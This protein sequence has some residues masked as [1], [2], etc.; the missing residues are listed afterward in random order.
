M[1]SFDAPLT[2]RAPPAGFI[3]RDARAPF[4]ALSRRYVG[5]PGGQTHLLEAGQ[6]SN[7]PSLWCLH[8]TAYAGRSFAPLLEALAGRRRVVAPDTM[9]YGG[10]DKPSEPIEI[11]DYARLIDE[12]LDAAGEGRIDL[13]GYHT[14]ALVAAELAGLR[15]DRVRRL[16]LIGVPYL[17][18]H[19]QKAWRDRLAKPAQL[20][21]GLEQFQERWDFLVAQRD[22]SVSLKRAFENFVDE[23]RAYPDGWWAHDAAFTFDVAGCFAKVSQPV[24]I[25]NPDNPLASPSRRAAKRL[26]NVRIVELKHLSHGIFDRAPDEIAFL[27]EA[28]LRE[29]EPA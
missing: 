3:R 22:P 4:S 17:E 2:S 7:E 10:S 23:L 26:A 1:T 24:L 11:G 16:I 5:P 14:G 6:V 12:A 29:A 27:T 8:A 13:L 20:G 9:G 25:L 18:G 19:E 21:D 28:F 15:P